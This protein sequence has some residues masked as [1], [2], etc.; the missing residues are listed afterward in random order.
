VPP[1]CANL[2]SEIFIASRSS[3]L[4]NNSSAEIM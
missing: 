1:T 4:Q 3:L 2:E